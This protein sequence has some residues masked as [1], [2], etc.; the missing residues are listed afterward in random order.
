V[1]RVAS[2]KCTLDIDDVITSV[3]DSLLFSLSSF[4][5]LSPLPLP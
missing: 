5:P 2:N 4:L 1:R 3:P